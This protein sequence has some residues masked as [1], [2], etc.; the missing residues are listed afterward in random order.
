MLAQNGL[1]EKIVEAVKEEHIQDVSDVRNESGRE[2]QTRIVVELKKG[3]DPR[4]VEKQL[5]EF[6]PLQQT[7]SIINIALV[8]RQPR[9]L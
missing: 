2:A 1:V 3:A 6:T 8:N 5:Y 9:T 7:F 4:V